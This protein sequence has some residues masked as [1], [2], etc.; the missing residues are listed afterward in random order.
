[1]ENNILAVIN[2]KEITESDLQVAITRLPRDK[3]SFFATPQ[4]KKQLLEQ[5]ISFELFYNYGKDNGIENDESYKAQIEIAKNDLITQCAIN[6]V[7]KDVN[8]TDEEVEKYYEA[9]RSYFMNEEEV[10]AS[11][12]LVATLEEAQEVAKKLK[13]GMDFEA[14]AKEFSSCPSSA[15]GGNLGKFS[16]GRMVPEFEEAAFALKVGE[17][18]EPVKT[19][20]GYHIIKVIEKFEAELRPFS[21]VS[22]LIK[23]QLLQERQSFKYMQ[24]AEDLK[25]T[26]KVEIK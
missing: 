5:I 22:A 13:E 21:E 16:R 4:G 12:I 2:G 18:S 7:L 19:Q 24:F 1:M 20:F 26:Y 14:A 15:Q 9:N 10:M 3:Q 11:H 6:S 25:Q 17:I 8:V 23:N